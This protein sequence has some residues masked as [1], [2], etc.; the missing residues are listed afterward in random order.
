MYIKRG[1]SITK[2]NGKVIQSVKDVK[3]KD[4]LEI[5]V[6]DGIINAEA[7][8][9]DNMAKEKELNFEENLEKLEELVKDLENGNVP[10]DDAINKYQEAMKIAKVC[11]EKL[12]SAEEAIT[13]I[14]KDDNS[15][16]DFEVTEE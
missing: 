16:E 9:E 10:L 1:Y 4:K 8:Q 15:V 5:E 14:V 11:D 6:S 3:K 12:K 2:N 13:K 7:L